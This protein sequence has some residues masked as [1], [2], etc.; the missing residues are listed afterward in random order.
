MKR[1][2][3]S[4]AACLLFQGGIAQASDKLVELPGY[5]TPIPQDILTPDE[6]ETRFGTLKFVDGRPTPETSALMYD[7][8]DFMRGVEVFLNFIPATSIEG[9]RRGM[10][11]IGVNQAHKVAVFEEL[12]DSNPLFLTGNTDT[13]YAS[14]ILDLGRDGPTVIEVPKG[15]GPTTVNDAYFRFVTDMGVPGPD[16]GEGGKYLILPPDYDGDL[17]PPVGGYEAEVEGETYFVSKSTSYINWFIARGFLVDGKT[18]TAVAAYR[19]GLKIYPLKD[20]ASPPQMEFVNASK[21][22]FNTI[23]ANTFEFYNELNT[24]LQKEPISTFDPEL[25][26]LAAAIGIQ[27]GKD[28]AP[29]ERM[30]Q[31]LTEAVA[32]GNATARTIWLKPRDKAAY[33]YENSGWFTAFIGGSW[34]WLR[35]EGKGGRYLDARTMFFYMATVN[36]PAMVLK[37]PGKG[38]QYAL[39]VTDSSGAFL[40]GSKSY[41]LTIPANAPAKDFWSVVVYDPQTRSELQTSQPFPSKNNKRDKL[42]ENEDGSVTLHFGPE[43][44]AGKEDNWVQ[45]VAGKGWFAILRLYGP[46]EA[47]FEK[48]WRPGEIEPAG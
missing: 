16:K 48:T 14:S 7:T 29:D 3:L 19:D 42:V 35:D 25:R 32:I 33:L 28:F 11:K 6:V 34:E 46:E 17:D 44:P 12:M 43:A 9:I 22:V 26:G 13:V 36:T 38:S 41:S 5:N 15:Q 39:T 2:G 24:V 20:K 31:L 21:K 40:D 8:L 45:T 10:D 27:K 4:L 47:W 30:T 37:I 23:H 18:D 1:F